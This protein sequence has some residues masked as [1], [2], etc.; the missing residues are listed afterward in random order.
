[1]VRVSICA[2][3]VCRALGISTAIADQGAG[4]VQIRSFPGRVAKASV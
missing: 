3:K 4:Y 2:I 1:M